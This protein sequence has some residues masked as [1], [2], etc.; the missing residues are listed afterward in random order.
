[1]Y[2]ENLIVNHHAERQVVEEVCKVVPDVCTVILAD[3][4]SVKAVGLRHSARLV[5]TS[6]Q[7]DAIRVSQFQAN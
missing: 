5:V 3:A 7:M 2:A 4:L 1:M 6:D